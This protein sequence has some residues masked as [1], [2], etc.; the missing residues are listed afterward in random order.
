MGSTCSTARQGRGNQSQKFAFPPRCLT[1]LSFLCPIDFLIATMLGL[2]ELDT[3]VCEQLRRHDIAQC[4]RVS[5]E[6][7]A[8]VIL[9]LWSNLTCLKRVSCPRKDAFRR[10]VQEDY[11]GGT[12]RLRLREVTKL[13]GNIFKHHLLSCRPCQNTELGF[14]SCRLWRPWKELFDLQRLQNKTTPCQ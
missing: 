7:H 3:I 2:P 1:S 6:W 13:W 11:L 9:H 5:K 8:A 12:Q 4:A 10:M 14:K